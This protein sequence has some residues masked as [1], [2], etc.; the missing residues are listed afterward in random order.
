MSFY[1][2]EA[3]FL[4]LLLPLFYF[5][6]IKR[7]ESLFDLSVEMYKK[8]VINRFDKKKQSI[9]LAFSFIFMVIA[10]A[11]PVYYKTKI[12]NSEINVDM[13][14]AFDISKSMMAKDIYPNRF[15]FAKNKMSS[16][17]DMFTTERIS[18]FA[19][20]NQAF[21]ISPLTNNYEVLRFLVE[22][23]KLENVN[24]SGTNILKLLGAANELIKKEKKPL[25]IF[26]DGS[27]NID[28]KKE[29]EFANE[30]GI[31]VFIYNIA[32]KR[33]GVIDENGK[34]IKDKNG[35]IV[36]SKINKKIE[37]LAKESDGE[38][39]G[40][41]LKNDDLKDIMK[42]IKSE[43]NID[44]SVDKNLQNKTELFLIPLLFAFIFLLL[45]RV[46]LKGFR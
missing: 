22:N 8:I 34:L 12:D 29:I 6:K 35:N 30:N 1:N 18:L 37:N 17:I 43:F 4:L 13:A 19:F 24:Q 32:T 46:N 20:S 23:L 10:M 33:G 42:R 41:S 40:Y 15:E 39:L 25:L 44:E 16:L 38:Y 27:E 31:S 36:V 21:I 9:F 26:T 11:R 45:S 2:I 5:V 3:L 28:F 14:I 7:D